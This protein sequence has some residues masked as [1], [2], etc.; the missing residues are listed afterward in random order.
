MTSHY[1]CSGCHRQNCSK[2]AIDGKDCLG[3]KP[4][5]EYFPEEPVCLLC[6]KMCINLRKYGRDCLGYK[7][8]VEKTQR[9]YIWIKEGY[10]DE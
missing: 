3:K 7:N 1:T 8:G 4:K 5:E 9:K 6:D 2:Y 10:D